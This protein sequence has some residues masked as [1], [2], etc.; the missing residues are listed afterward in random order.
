[1]RTQS[2]SWDSLHDLHMN[3]DRLLCMDN[4]NCTFVHPTH[5]R[6]QPVGVY[7]RVVKNLAHLVPAGHKCD[8]RIYSTSSSMENCVGSFLNSRQI[9]FSFDFVRLISL[10][11]KEN[12]TSKPSHKASER[13][14]PCR[15]PPPLLLPPSATPDF[16]GKDGTVESL[17]TPQDCYD[18]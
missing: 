14:R 17:Q 1:M 3:F 5:I 7:V 18:D 11:K 15:R 16:S 2:S 13:N 12:P 10:T 6:S 8:S 9:F 4:H